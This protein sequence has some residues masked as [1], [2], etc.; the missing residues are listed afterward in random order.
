MNDFEYIDNFIYKYFN[1]IHEEKKEYFKTLLKEIRKKNYRVI[2]IMNDIEEK[3]KTGSLLVPKGLL[4]IL[5]K[6]FP[7]LIS[8]ISK[9]LQIQKLIREVKSSNIL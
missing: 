4:N 7:F 9:T 6:E 8:D 5:E 2:L 1:N 3:I